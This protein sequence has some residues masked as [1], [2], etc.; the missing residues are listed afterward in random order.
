MQDYLGVNV[1]M[2]INQCYTLH[3]NRTTEYLLNYDNEDFAAALEMMK[4]LMRIWK[5]YQCPAQVFQSV[6]F[7]FCVQIVGQPVQ[8]KIWTPVLAV[9]CARF[10]KNKPLIPI[11]ANL[12]TS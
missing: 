9:L 3:Y 12:S 10:K 2:D 6:L 8:R 11:T 4:P 5:S 7:P 1:V